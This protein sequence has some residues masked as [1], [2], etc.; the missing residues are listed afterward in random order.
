MS[1]KQ[2]IKT[3]FRCRPLRLLFHQAKKNVEGLNSKKN[4]TRRAQIKNYLAF[5]C[6]LHSPKRHRLVASCQFC[7]LV[8]TCQHVATS[9]SISSSC[10][11]PVEIN[12]LKQLAPS[13]LI[14]HLDNERA[15]SLLTTCKTWRQ[16]TVASHANASWCRLVVTS[17]CKMSTDFLQLAR[18]WLWIAWAALWQSETKLRNQEKQ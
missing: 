3:W 12:L 1:Q 18:F 16:Q 4:S 7:Q 13:L 9:L 6:Y 15:S 14:S 17:C 11:K 2:V 10:N 5:M 8:A